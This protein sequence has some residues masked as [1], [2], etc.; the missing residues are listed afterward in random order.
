MQQV[1]AIAILTS[2]ASQQV[3]AQ[4]V[5]ISDDRTAPVTS[6]GE[7]GTGSGTL[8]LA[9]DGS[10][11]INQGTALT[12]N[13]PHNFT[14]EATSSISSADL[15]AGRG[16]LVDA[17]TQR[18]ISNIEIGG[19]IVAGDPGTNTLDIDLATSNVGLELAGDFGLDGDVTIT[20]DGRITVNGADGRGILID[21]PMEG[22]LTQSGAILT[23][24]NRAIGMDLNGPI[25]GDVVMDGSIT[26]RNADT[27]GIRVGDTI[28]GGFVH[29][30]SITVGAPAT[31]DGND[32]I[33]A[34]PATAGIQVEADV[35][36]GIL[37]D[38]IGANNDLDL[39]GDGT[40]D[41]SS[42][43]TI[44]S[45][46]GAPALV[47]A[48]P[49][50]ASSPLV[51]GEVDGLGYSYVQRGNIVVNGTSNGLAAS[52][53]R[54]SGQSGA[55]TQITNG[56]FFDTGNVTVRSADADSVGI[57]IGNYAE[58]PEIVNTGTLD[59]DT[60]TSS[61]VLNGDDDDANND[62]T[63]FGPG[64]E[65]T[66]ILIREQGTLTSLT[67]EGNINATARGVGQDAYAIRDLSGTLATV[68]NSGVITAATED[69]GASAYAIDVRNNTGGFTLNNTGTIIGDLA[70][71]NGND[72][73]N[74]SD[75]EV[76]GDIF[77]S[78]GADVLNL[79][80]DAVLTGS[81]DFDGT[82][83]LNVDGADLEL[84]DTDTFHVTNAS[85]SNDSN[86]IF[87][88]DLENSEAGHIT[89][90]NMLTATADVNLQPVFTSFTD[91]NQ[92]FD[93]ISAG[94]L[95]FADSAASL[96]LSNTPYLFDVSLDIVS[97]IDNSTVTLNV[98]PKTAEELGVSA[99]NTA[100]YDNIINSGLVL[101]NQLEASLAG[102]ISKDDVEAAFAALTP[103][104]TNASFN[105]ALM[106]ERQFA[107]HLASRLTDFLSEDRFEGGAWVREVT[108]IGDH[109]ASDSY[110][111]SN[112]LSVGLTM[113]YDQPLSKNFALG[114]NGGFTL[115]GF[116]GTDDTINS[117][118]SSFAPFLSVY[119][120][121]R[122]GGLYVGV[123]ATGQYVS[124]ERERTLAFGSLNRIVTSTTSGW[125][126][127]ATAEAGY[128]LKLGGL[129][130]KPY[131]RI[132]AQH[133]SESGY[134]EDGGDSANLTVGKRSFNRTQA[135]FGA[136][137]GYDFKW[138][139]QRE[140]KIFRPEVFYTYA[141][142]IAGAD[143]E[144]LDSIFVAGDT[145]FALEIDQMAERIEQ[146]GGAVNLFG[147]GSKARVHYAYEK[148]DDVVGHALS[149]N[150]A[151]TF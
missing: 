42:D 104:T 40:A 45:T 92:S 145:S 118:L 81:V 62:E 36:G 37:L 131:G 83:D 146:Y 100:L 143:P 60:F 124:L 84:R 47:I 27:I 148:L 90:D 127:A 120:M 87:N 112:I 13:G 28:D 97:A 66:T 79:S 58:V 57:D 31:T 99:N 50:G 132:S 24:G 116:S 128:D 86:L 129:H 113:G 111:N 41:I 44:S 95:N 77:F 140:T 51:I 93:L 107:G 149:V 33:D 22:N 75:G 96:A 4:D 94:A 30:G 139:R 20:S 34:I 49:D 134:T 91:D 46:G 142:T 130:L 117:E 16:L 14:M 147:D 108:N 82:L 76:Q 63:I 10:I 85:F 11:I 48:N 39:D 88:V 110:L 23:V 59:V 137:L 78:G 121:G 19:D 56:M 114:V 2:L 52:G 17:T 98:R 32:D 89:I 71:G 29:R 12:I 55:P 123:Q 18:I 21:G 144:A 53:I 7:I 70:L 125:N 38:G 9:A 133:Y 135:S 101:D 35:T 68:T 151:L 61:T 54:L 105:S 15:V 74:L 25:T 43:S 26:S 109:T 122:A 80:G 102:L 72:T 136:S 69:S 73:V 1:S 5:T 6:T 150:F 138:K 141:K 115:N 3:A 106:S 119:G 64:G 126:L 67:N 103:D 8:T 65:A